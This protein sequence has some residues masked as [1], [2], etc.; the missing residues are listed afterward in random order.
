MSN[1][2]LFPE[3]GFPKPLSINPAQFVPQSDNWDWAIMGTSLR[4]RTDLEVHHF[5]APVNLPAG[6]RVTK[7]KIYGARESVT[8]V[9]D[10]RLYREDIA[11]ENK[12]EMARVTA[13]WTGDGSGEDT[14]I[15]EDVIDNVNYCYSLHCQV[16]PDT[17]V[18]L[19]KLYAVV[20]DWK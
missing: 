17:D 16:D 12:T 20:I 1:F 7:L 5:R 15:A 9:L 3:K 8:A 10:V 4:N 19:T 11:S 14:S 13:D 6:A 18:L 2:G